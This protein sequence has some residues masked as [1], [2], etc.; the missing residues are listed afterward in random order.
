MLCAYV[1][2]GAQWLPEAALDRSRLGTGTNASVRD[3]SAVRA[4]AGG[5]VAVLKGERYPGNAGRGLVH[6]SPPASA[7]SP[8]VVLAIDFG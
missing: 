2:A 8:R 3:W 1:G 6:R 4:L 5:E 7:Q